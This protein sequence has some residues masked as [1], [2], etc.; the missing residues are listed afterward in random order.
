MWSS[1]MGLALM[2]TLN[3][4]RLGVLLLLISRQKPAQNLL[5]FWIGC[6]TV[7][8][9]LIVG[10]LLLLH[11]TP[12]F[13]SFSDRL[14]APSDKSRFAHLQIGIGLF[15]LFV[16]AAIAARMRLRRRAGAAVAPTGDGLLSSPG[17][18]PGAM[19]APADAPGS[20]ESDL[21]RGTSRRLVARARDAWN[22]GTLWVAFAVGLAMGPA[23]EIVVVVLAVIATSGATASVQLVAAVAYIAGVLAVV[24]IAL[25]SYVLAPA[26]TEPVLRR[27][28]GWALVHRL[29]VLVVIF[30]VVGISSLVRGLSVV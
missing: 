25:I 9:F 22:S 2:G 17:T 19:A 10:P 21:L 11:F 6:L 7:S 8:L 4:V 20:E 15:A 29:H 26:R 3:P 1:V 23:P 30:A 5:A 24:E 27:L 18:G 16:A 13:D 14:T 28:R 12:L